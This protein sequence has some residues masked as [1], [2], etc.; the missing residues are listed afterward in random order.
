MSII[1]W[2]I[3]ELSRCV[4]WDENGQINSPSDC[5]QKKELE[6]GSNL[7]WDSQ[8]SQSIEILVW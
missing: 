7:Q 4:I 6:L 1:A 8:I 5:P 3:S 2:L